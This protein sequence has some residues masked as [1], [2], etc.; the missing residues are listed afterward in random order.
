MR[1]FNKDFV[2]LIWGPQAPSLPNAIWAPG[3][4]W[5]EA[6]NT[7]LDHV[8]LQGK[9]YIYLIFTDDDAS[10]SMR[11]SSAPE[12]ALIEQLDDPW[13]EFERLLLK[14]LPAAGYARYTIQQPQETKKDEPEIECVRCLCVCVCVCVCVY[15]FVCVCVYIY[16][17]RYIC[18]YVR[19]Y[20]C[21]YICVCMYIHT[22]NTYDVYTRI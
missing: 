9:H 12:G 18:L 14:W 10:L 16:I 13:R 4:T 21:I 2:Q 3:C 1:V 19:T 17:Y 5:N 20:E 11:P 8:R 15:V 7:L 6:R 22:Y